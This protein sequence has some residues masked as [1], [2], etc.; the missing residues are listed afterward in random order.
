MKDQLIQ[1]F[2]SLMA[3]IPQ[4]IEPPVPSEKWEQYL[5]DVLSLIVNTDIDE[6]TPLPDVGSGDKGK[7]LHTNES[8]GA[9]EWADGGS[10]GGVLVVTPD[11]NDTLDK[12]WQEIYDAFATG[13]VR[14]DNGDGLVS[15]TGVYESSGNDYIVMVSDGGDIKASFIASSADS[16]PGLQE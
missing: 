15:V 8:T 9:L 7:F 5:G 13:V 10:G 2:T 1:L 6:P 11:E 4:E 14:F 16:Y 12:T 3:K